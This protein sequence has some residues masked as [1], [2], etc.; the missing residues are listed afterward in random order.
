MEP[1]KPSVE[2]VFKDSYGKI[3]S[4]LLHR[5]FDLPTAEDALSAAFETAIRNWALS[6][7]PAQPESWLFTV[8][9]HR[10]IDI[11]RKLSRTTSIEESRLTSIPFSDSDEP[12]GDERLRLFFLCT[13]PAIDSQ[14]QTPLMLQLI[15]GFSAREISDAYL[16]NEVT[17]SQ[18]L[19]R[20]KKKVQIANIAPEL[21]SPDQLESRSCSVMES[22]YALYCRG[23]EQPRESSRISLAREAEDLARILLALLSDNPEAMGLLALILFCDGRR[24]ARTGVEGAFIPLD[25]QDMEAWNWQILREAE[26]LLKSASARSRPGR[27]Q[28]E[29]AIQSAHV[30]RRATGFPAWDQI[31][32]LYDLLLSVAPTTANQLGRVAVLAR[33]QGP[34]AAL[35]ALSSLETGGTY[36]PFYAVRSSILADL[37]RTSEARA[38]AQRAIELSDDPSIKDHFR[39]FIELLLS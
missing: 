23:W 25:E 8:A 4:A 28:L 33:V 7:T 14:S 37:G 39:R 36:Q 2:Q 17:M 16:V 32:K 18:R 27:F 20:A 6:S 13:H 26:G 11:K 35:D 5:G 30:S 29:A 10:A 9:N 38:D 24:G 19:V 34:E 12:I 22:V 31:L 21:P 1:A 15:L 3:L